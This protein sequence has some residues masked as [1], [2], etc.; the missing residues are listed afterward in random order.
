MGQRG[1][2][3]PNLA[4][5]RGVLDGKTHIFL[6]YFDDFQKQRVF[7]RRA[8]GA[9]DIRLKTVVFAPGGSL[10]ASLEGS[11]LALGS[12]GGSRHHHH[13]FFWRQGGPLGAAKACVIANYDGKTRV[14]Y[15]FDF[16][17]ERS[18]KRP[19]ER[20]NLRFGAKEG[21]GT[22]PEKL[23]SEFGAKTGRGSGQNGPIWRNVRGQWG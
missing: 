17:L 14:F 8:P 12:L 19:G 21:P 22:P 16:R 9:L 13:V 15:D 20:K 23:N 5:Q 2:W 7:Q 10:G 11:F 18:W 4:M 1:P 3:K 6:W